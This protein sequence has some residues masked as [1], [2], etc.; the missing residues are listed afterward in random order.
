MVTIPWVLVVAKHWN[1]LD[2]PDNE[3][4]IH[5]RATPSLGGI[6]IMLAFLVSIMVIQGMEDYYKMG[7]IALCTSVLTLVGI[8]DDLF[9][10]KAQHKFLWQLSVALL[11]AILM[12]HW[13]YSL[14]GYFGIEQLPFAIGFGFSILFLVFFTNAYN[15]IDGV[16]GLAGSL[17]IWICLSMGLV[18]YLADDRVFALMALALAGS[19]A[20][21]LR[22]NYA[23]ARIFMGDTGSL[24]VGFMLAVFALRFMS[25]ES[26]KLDEQLLPL[27][28]HAPL[29]AFSFLIIPIYD[30]LRVILVRIG[31]KK[32][33]FEPGRDHIHHEMLNTGFQ[34][35][36]VALYTLGVNI[37]ISGSVIM[38]VYSNRHPY[39]IMFLLCLLAIA[40]LP[41]VGIKR[42]MIR[43]V[44]ND[45]LPALK[46]NVPHQSDLQ[47]KLDLPQEKVIDFPKETEKR[48]SR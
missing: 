25:R 20:G 11:F 35:S 21:F 27:Y 48:L 17:G 43:F 26:Y 8:R 46:G 7:V 22:F 3:R 47:K 19:I 1:L 10:M 29:I 34:H 39:F 30:T 18:S 37:L 13:T 24:T 6:G 5:A 12:S 42:I 2:E 31:G 4:K 38:L 28:R 40:L 23:P 44:L 15:L 41:T 9:H 45:L 32:S 14:R 36:S 16:D 33:P